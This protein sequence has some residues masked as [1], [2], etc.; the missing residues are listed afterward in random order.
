[1]NEKARLSLKSKL[2]AELP[3]LRAFALSLAGSSDGADDLVQDTL[4]KA[5]AN[6]SSFAEGT[7]MRAW[8]F[9]IMRNTFFS[10]YRKSRREVQDVDGEAAARLVA[11]PDQLAHLDLADFRA[12]LERLPADQREALILIGASGF[13]YEEAAE[14]CGCA[15][16]TIKSRVNRARRRL[17]DLLALSSIDDFA[18]DPELT[19]SVAA[20]RFGE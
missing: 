3:S 14:I 5:W 18:A 15:V 19:D 2:L 11:M 12:R 10:K 16:G 17:M 7:N 6:A 8:L 1:M 20:V 4:M 13:S 9:T